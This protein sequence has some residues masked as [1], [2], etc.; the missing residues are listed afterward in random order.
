LEPIRERR[1]KYEEN[2]QLVWDI[3]ENGRKK[4]REVAQKNMLEIKEK[5]KIN[6]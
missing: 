6:Y 4:V 2:P 3:L 1:K 5:M